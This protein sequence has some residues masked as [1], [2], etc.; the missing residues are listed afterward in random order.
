MKAFV[1]KLVEKFN[2][3]VL[4]IFSIVLG[5]LALLAGIFT[6]AQGAKEGCG[7][8][9]NLLVMSVLFFILAF[10]LYKDDKKKSFIVSLILL[11]DFV[12]T[13]FGNSV[14]QFVYAGDA[15]GAI[16]AGMAFIGLGALALFAA[17]IIHVV[18]LLKDGCSKDL[19]HFI[20]TL[21]FVI[22][23]FFYFLGSILMVCEGGDGLYI[24]TFLFT[25]FLIAGEAVMF[26]FGGK[27]LLSAE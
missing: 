6:I 10:L 14:T 27:K 20:C 21:I 1:S 9:L 19:L 25:N 5:S 16:I 15:Y 11:A 22:G 2:N 24:V 18:M 4:M 7:T 26:G 13:G 17:G 3:K 8:F 12:L 23:G